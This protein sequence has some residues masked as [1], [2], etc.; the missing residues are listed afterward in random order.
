M[1]IVVYL[2]RLLCPLLPQ[3]KTGVERCSPHPSQCTFVFGVR[4][5]ASETKETSRVEET[6][7]RLFK[8]ATT[9]A[10]LLVLSPLLPRPHP[11]PFQPP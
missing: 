11:L 8:R 7:R 1:P 2:S 6:E 9:S 4:S 3:L 5:Q 10:G